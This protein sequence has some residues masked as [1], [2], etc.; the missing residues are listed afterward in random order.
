MSGMRIIA[1]L[2][3]GF[4]AGFFLRPVLSPVAALTSFMVKPTEEE[5]TAPCAGISIAD[6]VLRREFGR[7]DREVR[8]LPARRR[9]SRRDVYDGSKHRPGQA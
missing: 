4:G 7:G 6:A 9:P 1:A 5:A 8:G 2:A 3:V